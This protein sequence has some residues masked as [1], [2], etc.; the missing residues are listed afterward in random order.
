MRL[1]KLAMALAA[2]ATM[3]SAGVAQADGD[4]RE[5]TGT[6]LLR[7]QMAAASWERAELCVHTNSTRGTARRERAGSRP[8]SASLS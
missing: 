2:G 8:S 7:R 5:A 3:L 6:A 1:P 4:A